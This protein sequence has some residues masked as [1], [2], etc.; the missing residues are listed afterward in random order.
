[1]L[2]QRVLSQQ[3]PAALGSPGAGLGC[4]LVLLVLLVLLELLV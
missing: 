2:A 1:V 3:R 4:A